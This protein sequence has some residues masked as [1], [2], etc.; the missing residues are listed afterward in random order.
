MY[1]YCGKI[2]NVDLTS[3]EISTSDV[4]EKDFFLFMG[5]AGLA[6][7]MYLEDWPGDVDPLDPGNPLYFMTG[8]WT[9]SRIPGGNRFEIL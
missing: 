1:A 8:P 3:G 4:D 2:L 6:A 9:G 5:G 7:K